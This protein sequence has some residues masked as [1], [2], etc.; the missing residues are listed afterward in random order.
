MCQ[1]AEN[2]EQVFKILILKFLVNFLHFKLGLEHW[3]YPGP[4]VFFS[5]WS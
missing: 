5:C 4:H 3:S 2:V 1:N